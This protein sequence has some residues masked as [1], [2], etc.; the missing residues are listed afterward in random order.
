[1]N[2]SSHL[3]RDNAFWSEAHKYIPQVMLNCAVVGLDQTRL[4]EIGKWAW[5]AHTSD[6]V[7]EA[8]FC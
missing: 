3:N 7:T 4:E 1:M 2:F 6:S 5:P 8:H